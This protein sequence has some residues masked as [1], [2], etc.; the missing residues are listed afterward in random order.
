[1]PLALLALCPPSRWPARVRFARA[2][3]LPIAAL[4]IGQFG[5]LIALLNY[6]LRTVP[7]GRGA[8]IFASFPLHHARSRRIARP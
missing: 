1:M 4:G 8:L 6:G 7:A 3:I 5:I 2:D